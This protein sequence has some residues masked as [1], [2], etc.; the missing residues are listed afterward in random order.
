MITIDNLMDKANAK[1]HGLGPV[2]AVRVTQEDY[3]FLQRTGAWGGLKL[4]NLLRAC[5]S[6]VHGEVGDAP[7]VES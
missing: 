3:Q 7:G 4:S 2:I 6:L 1:P 5:V